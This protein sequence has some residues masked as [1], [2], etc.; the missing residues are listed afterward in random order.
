MANRKENQS[1]SVALPVH[2]G[3]LAYRLNL[4]E[5]KI[6]LTK[7]TKSKEVL[8][9]KIL[10][11]TD[12][13]NKLKDTMYEIY[14]K[15]YG[16]TSEALFQEDLQ[17]KNFCILIFNQSEQL[18]GFSSLLIFTAALKGESFGIVYSGDT[19]I[20]HEYWG[21]NILI[22][23]WL[24]LTGKIYRQM[25]T[26]PWFWLLLVKGHRT[27]RYLNLF[28]KEFYPR[29]EAFIPRG[30]KEKRDLITKMKFGQCFDEKRGIIKFPETKGFLKE[31]WAGLNQK[32]KN[33]PEANFFQSQNPGFGEGDELV[34]F[35]EISEKNF[36][37]RAL[38]L[39][40]DEFYN[41]ILHQASWNRLL[42]E[43]EIPKI[44]L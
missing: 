43:L 17:N 18:V 6:M 14:E 34:C 28:F 12:L 26:I 1:F 24:G 4:E 16:G 20:K 33:H 38:V 10:A 9:A 29:P 13:E 21:S 15:Y 25:N 32:T 30:W 37:K 36:K 44:N 23:A 42:K 41:E 11:V 8:K 35:C 7:T 27:Y 31:E 3:Q 2:A 40:K 19:I 22:K 5:H 39:F